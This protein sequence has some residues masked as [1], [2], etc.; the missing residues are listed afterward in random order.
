MTTKASEQALEKAVTKARDKSAATNH[1]HSIWLTREGEFR[2][3]PMFEKVSP[4]WTLVQ[5]VPSEKELGRG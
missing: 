2:V 1:R 3:R 5:H 4:L